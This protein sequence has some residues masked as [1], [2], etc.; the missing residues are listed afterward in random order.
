MD[1]ECDEGI[2]CNG[3]ETCDLDTGS[4]QAGSLDVW[5]DELSCTFDWCDGVTDSGM[6]L[7]VDDRWVDSY[8]CNGIETCDPSNP[9]GD[10]VTG[11]VSGNPLARV[12]E[13]EADFAT[14]SNIVI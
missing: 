4:C 11:C 1:S 7:D 2:F 8:V 13:H 6:T 10:N 14:V 5:D 3:V 12:C 9:A